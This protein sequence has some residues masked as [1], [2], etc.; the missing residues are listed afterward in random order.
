MGPSQRK[1]IVVLL[2]LCNRHLP[3]K[4]RMALFAVRSQ[5]PAVDVGV[6]VLASLANVGEHWLDV[7]LRAGYCLMHAAQ[8]IPS[9][10]VIE[11][12]NGA[13]RAPGRGGVAI[14][15]WHVQVPVRTVGSSGRLRLGA[16]T[17]RN[18]HNEQPYLIAHRP[19]AQHGPFLASLRTTLE[20]RFV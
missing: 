9:L 7:A 16:R 2:D 13:N 14:L 15:A 4:Y 3:A 19:N 11:F 8:R 5:L 1:A 12:R 17:E 18:Q 6:A 20:K 10:I